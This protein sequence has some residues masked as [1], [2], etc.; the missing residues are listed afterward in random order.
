[1]QKIWLRILGMVQEIVVAKCDMEFPLEK[2]DVELVER[3]GILGSSM[4]L[5]RDKR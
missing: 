1:M 5:A 3:L 2:R 4:A